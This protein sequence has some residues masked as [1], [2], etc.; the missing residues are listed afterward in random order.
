MVSWHECGEWGTSSMGTKAASLTSSPITSGRCESVW[1]ILTKHGPS[2][3]SSFESSSPRVRFST[4]HDSWLSHI[5]WRELIERVIRASRAATI[6]GR[7][8]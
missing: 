8:E 2:A 1:P 5:R 4:G 7:L 3:V 6:C